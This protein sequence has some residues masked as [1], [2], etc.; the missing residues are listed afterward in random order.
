MRRILLVLSVALVLA[1]MM[2]AMATPAIA[3][4]KSE[5][6]ECSDGGLVLKEV[7]KQIEKTQPLECEKFKG[8]SAQ[9]D[10]W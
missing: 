10:S 1:A 2:L 9:V 7:A 6:Y 4:M 8:Q 5:L 3:K